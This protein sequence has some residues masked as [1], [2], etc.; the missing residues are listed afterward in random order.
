MTGLL[1]SVRSADE[2]QA[3][4]RGGADVID[5]KEPA[6]GPLGPADP[7][8]W[9]QVQQV[10]GHRRPLSVAL[11][12]LWT[13]AMAE[14]WQVQGMR[15]VKIGLAGCQDKPDWPQRWAAAVAKLPAQVEAVPV[16]Y[17]DWQAAMAPEPEHVVDW[18]ARGHAQSL[19]VDT[20]DKRS[21]PLT[22]LW[23]QD[24][25]D[26]LVQKVRAAGLR[27]VLA[28]RLDATTLPLVVPWRPDY[29]G[30]RGAVCRGGRDGT[31]DAQLVKTL[32]RLLPCEKAAAPSC[33]LTS[34]LPGRILPA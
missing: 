21:G 26:R 32:R 1:V 13:D 27:L 19:V 18:A 9:R 24:R 33:S 30:V 28:G 25:L 2:A 11:G 15:W 23:P 22:A 14:T 3:A 10:V 16:A 6:R 7:A 17:A 31:I 20:F 4:L 8:I 29:V 12:E 34:P 5:I